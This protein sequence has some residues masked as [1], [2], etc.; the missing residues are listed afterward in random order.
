MSD[1]VT[2]DL[3]QVG[4]EVHGDTGWQR[5]TEVMTAPGNYGSTQYVFLL[6]GGGFTTCTSNQEI[7]A[8]AGSQR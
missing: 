2:G 1:Y 8:R 7:R 5:V 6:A 4:W 3:V